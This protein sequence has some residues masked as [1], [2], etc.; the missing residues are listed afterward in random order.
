METR[1]S[2]LSQAK[3]SVKKKGW[4]K[5]VIAF[6]G[7]VAVVTA[8]WIGNSAQDNYCTSNFGPHAMAYSQS[9]KTAGPERCE[10]QNEYWLSDVS[11]TC[12]SLESVCQE[13]GVPPVSVMEKQ[14]GNAY[15]E[16]KTSDG[17]VKSIEGSLKGGRYPYYF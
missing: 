13:N 6:F 5:S 11:R 4:I 9:Y 8:I 2:T 7:A 10:C 15:L 1:P 3:S 17:K 12:I 14:S 16:C